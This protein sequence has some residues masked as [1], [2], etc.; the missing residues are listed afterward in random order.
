MNSQVARQAC[1]RAGLVCGW[2]AVF[3]S[4]VGEVVLAAVLVATP[5]AEGEAAV[6]VQVAV[7]GAYKSQD[8]AIKIPF[9]TLVRPPARFLTH[10]F[11]I[12]LFY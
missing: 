9:R 10:F 12:I 4:K 3:S 2:V 6:F 1:S 11:Y 8:Q 7:A 5:L